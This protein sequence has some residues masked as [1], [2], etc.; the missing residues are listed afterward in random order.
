MIETAQSGNLVGST[1]SDLSIGAPPA[2]S[3]SLLSLPTCRPH[4]AAAPPC[5]PRSVSLPPHPLPKPH[6]HH[7]PTTYPHPYPPP[8]PGSFMVNTTQ[9]LLASFA[10]WLSN[11]LLITV[12]V[13][14]L[15][16]GQRKRKH[17][18]RGA[19][20]LPPGNPPSPLPAGPPWR[21]QNTA[22]A[23][24][25]R[26]TTPRTETPRA[27]NTTSPNPPPPRAGRASSGASR[28]ASSATCPSSSPCPWRTA[29]WR[30]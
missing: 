25:P 26:N 29:S 6:T 10:N 14:Y 22:P 13:I 2:P 21:K 24:D 27:T 9:A 28:A 20:N 7:L 15:L 5:A 23:P 8:Y 3:L 4:P 11:L 19:R 18:R 12:F 17:P 30:G 1:I 16:E